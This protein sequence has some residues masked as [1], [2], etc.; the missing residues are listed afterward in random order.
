MSHEQYGFLFLALDTDG[1][2][3]SMWSLVII[4]ILTMAIGILLGIVIGDTI[5]DNRRLDNLERKIKLLE[6]KVK[7]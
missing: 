6:R 5:A 3:S 7:A 4:P 1:R 2:L